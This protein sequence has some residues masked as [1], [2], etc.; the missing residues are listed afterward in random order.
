MSFLYS[1]RRTPCSPQRTPDGTHHSA[2]RTQSRSGRAGPLIPATLSACALGT[3]ERT[4]RLL[5]HTSSS[6]CRRSR[7]S[8]IRRGGLAPR[9]RHSHPALARRHRAPNTVWFIG[10]Y[11][12][13]R[14]RHSYRTLVADPFCLHLV[15]LPQGSTLSFGVVEDIRRHS[16][17][18]RFDL[19]LQFI[20]RRFHAAKLWSCHGL[21]PDHPQTSGRV[22]AIRIHR[23]WSRMPA[24][25]DSHFGQCAPRN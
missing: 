5:T 17:T 15:L 6:C 20:Q 1:C 11:G 19:P 2:Y 13:G 18:D 12:M 22:D 10:S 7:C 14:A 3:G 23:V 24:V 4:G 25:G 21:A 16:A 9:P 8:L